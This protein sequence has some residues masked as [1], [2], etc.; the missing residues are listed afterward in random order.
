M[1][2]ILGQRLIRMHDGD[3]RSCKFHP[4][5]SLRNPAAQFIVINVMIRERFKPS[6]FPQALSRGGH[7]GPKSKL[8]ALQFLRKQRTGRE[9][10]SGTCSVKRRS[11]ATIGRAPEK[12]RDCANATIRKRRSHLFQIVRFNAHVAITDH[13]EIVLRRFH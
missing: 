2:K 13:K 1:A 12:N 7:G 9:L 3:N 4:E 8:D 5:T 6:N 11:S 10:D